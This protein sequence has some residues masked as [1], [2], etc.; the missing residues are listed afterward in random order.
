MKNKPL[1]FT[2]H[3]LE[4]MSKRGISKE[5]VKKVFENGKWRKGKNPFSFE[6]EFKGIIIIVYE[7][8]VR[9][10]VTTCKLNRENTIKAEKIKEELGVNFFVAMHKVVKELN[11]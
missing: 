9:Y 4:R 10:N 7:N 2:E 8:A 6:I 11:L 1:Y 5:V 3:Q